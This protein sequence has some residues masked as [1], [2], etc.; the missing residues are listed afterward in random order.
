MVIVLKNKETGKHHAH[1]QTD[2]TIENKTTFA[3]QLMHFRIFGLKCQFRSP[4]MWVL[5]DFGSINVIVHHQDPKR[6]ILA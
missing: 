4:K 2:K 3:T 1:P 6:H 5:G